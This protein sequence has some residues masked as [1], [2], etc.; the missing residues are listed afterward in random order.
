MSRASF[1]V[2]NVP[3]DRTIFVRMTGKFDI[4][5]MRAF[6]DEYRAATSTYSGAVHFVLADMR[7]MQAAQPEVGLMLGSAIGYARTHGVR[8]CAHLSDDTVQ[9]LQAAR[10]ARQ[11]T[12]GGDVT[13]DV[14]SLE[15]AERVIREHREKERPQLEQR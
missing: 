8:C 12:P 4:G 2:R 5:T 9:R 15:E 10:L 6:C 7:G 1:S 3:A 11:S 13:V 14:S